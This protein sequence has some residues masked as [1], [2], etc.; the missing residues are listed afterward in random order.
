MSIKPFSSFEIE[1]LREIIEKNGWNISANIENYFRYSIKKDKLILFTIKFPILLPLRLNIPF[2]IVN[3]RFCISFKLW[4]LNPNTNKIILYFIKMLRDLELKLTI[5]HNFPIKGKESELLELLNI[6]MPEP[7]RDEIESTWLNRI[8][9]SLMNKRDKLQQFDSTYIVQIVDVLRKIGL[10]PTFRLPWELKQGVPKI[11]TSETLFFSNDEPF[12]E[13]FIFEK[14]YISYFKDL[15]YNKFYIRAS[16][17]S[18]TPYVLTKLFNETDFKLEVYLENW[19]KF[20]RLILNSI[21]EIINLADINHND[22]IQFKPERELESNDFELDQNNFPFSALHYESSIAKRELYQIHNDLFNSPP[23]NFEVIETIQAYTEAEELIKN[24]R[25]NEA[26]EILNNS[27]KVFNK[28]HQRKVVVSILLKLEKI[29]SLLNQKDIRINYLES[30]LG[31]TKAG[32]VPIKYIVKIHHKLGKLYF[33]SNELVKAENHF[34]IIINFLEKE[35]TSLNKDEYLGMAYLYMGFISQ[36]NAKLVQAKNHFK[37]AF[38]LGS[39]SIKVKLSYHLLR[40]K[41]Y[42]TRGNLSQ[43]QK[44]LRT[45][46]DT[47]GIDFAEKKYVYLFYDIVLELAEFYIHHRIDSKKAM[48]LLKSVENRLSQNVKEIPGM[49]RAIRWNL[50][51]CDYNDMI[52]KDSSKSN[53]YYK[54]SQIFINQLKKIGVFD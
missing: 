2:E 51:M 52:A 7:I 50:L 34:N 15:E 29:A 23:T 27:L 42:K 48:F 45:A 46:I 32:D 3:F 14:G 37:M 24:Y 26:A 49:R 39:N 21:I 36:E 41:D 13:F 40:A 16:F 4:Y 19:I 5:E 17:D 6:L 31:V 12:D 22:F 10:Q 43:A 53:Y 47:V 30:A 28:N 9:I 54:Q 44:L 33:E 38:Q 18:Y 25:F 35:E 20:T 11:R 8:R 1:N